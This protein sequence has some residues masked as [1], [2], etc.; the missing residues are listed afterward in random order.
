MV[1]FNFLFAPNDSQ[2]AGIPLDIPLC[3]FDG[4]VC[5]RAVYVSY[6]IPVLLAVTI[7]LLL[8][9][10]LSSMAIWRHYKVSIR[11]FTSDVIILMAGGDK[12]RQNVLE[13]K[14]RGN[15]GWNNY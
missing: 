10:S 5:S 6:I 7:T 13:D 8:L 2:C 9:L 1:E 12:N 3:G 15:H 14:C 11:H 4:S